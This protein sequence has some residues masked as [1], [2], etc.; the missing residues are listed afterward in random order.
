MDEKE[1]IKRK[2]FAQLTTQ[3]KNSLKN[4]KEDQTQYRNSLNELKVLIVDQRERDTF[5]QLQRDSL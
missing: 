5:E 1:E 2:K 4:F 3:F